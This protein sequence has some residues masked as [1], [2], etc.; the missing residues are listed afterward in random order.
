MYLAHFALSKFKK[1]YEITRR[2]ILNNLFFFLFLLCL[3][4]VNSHQLFA[5]TCSPILLLWSL[6]V[7]KLLRFWLRIDFSSLWVTTSTSYLGQHFPVCF[8]AVFDIFLLFRENHWHSLFHK[9][10]V[11]FF[12]SQLQ[13]F[14]VFFQL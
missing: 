2:K 3:R 7:S 6:C 1:F 4:F 8:I 14:P 13:K 10:C 12:M 5:H 11:G 9:H